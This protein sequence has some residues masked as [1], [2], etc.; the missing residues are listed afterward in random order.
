MNDLNTPLSDWGWFVFGIIMLTLMA[1]FAPKFA[2][3]FTLLILTA[4]AINIHR[5]GLL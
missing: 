3:P 2:G 4:L 1:M 5:K